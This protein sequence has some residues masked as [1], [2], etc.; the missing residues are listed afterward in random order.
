MNKEQQER[1]D[2]AMSHLVRMLRAGPKG[3]CEA[4]V[5]KDSKDRWAGVY[6][7]GVDPVK[8]FRFYYGTDPW[9]PGPISYWRFPERDPVEDDQLITVEDVIAASELE[10]Q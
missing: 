8:G 10:P 3:H 4:M 6:I 1:Y 5:A 9:F 7:N 2:K